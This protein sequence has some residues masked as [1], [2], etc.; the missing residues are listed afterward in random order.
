MG[1]IFRPACAS[2]DCG[3]AAMELSVTCSWSADDP[4]RL[5][6]VVRAVT[7]THDASPSEPGP[8]ELPPP[9]VLTPP[10]A[11][12]AAPPP[13][14]ELYVT[15]PAGFELESCV[16]R[17]S[18]RNV[19]LYAAAAAAKAASL[20]ALE[21]CGSS[22]RGRALDDGAF[23]CTVQRQKDAVPGAGARS[24]VT[25]CVWQLQGI[26]TTSTSLVRM[27]A[28]LRLKLVSLST[29]REVILRSAVLHICGVRKPAA[30]AAAVPTPSQLPPQLRA[31]LSGMAVGNGVATSPKPAAK[32]AGAAAKG[33]ASS[34]EASLPQEL[35]ELRRATDERLAA[36]ERR[37]EQLCADVERRLSRLEQAVLGETKDD[38]P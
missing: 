24:T 9:V 25:S 1:D 38:A 5:Q 29:P 7:E 23:E 27:T 36:M 15:V 35:A 16:V 31:L 14:C 28:V 4:T 19:E 18:A 2:F 32:K 33:A 11:S 34:Q 3:A 10:E 26:L 37:V 6:R 20:S 8:S 13:A 22:G 30:P 17:S 12:G 21:Y